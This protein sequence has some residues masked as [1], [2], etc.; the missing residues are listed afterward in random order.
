MRCKPSSQVEE[1][2]FHS[3][4]SRGGPRR[5]PRLGYSMEAALERG[6]APEPPPCGGNEPVWV[7][8]PRIQV[9]GPRT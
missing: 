5:P 7:Q 8:P 3:A 2:T 4:L 9:P 1:V 6:L